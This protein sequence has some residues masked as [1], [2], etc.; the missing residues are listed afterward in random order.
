MTSISHN[1]PHCKSKEAS[2]LIVSEIKSQTDHYSWY[3]MARCGVC[4]EISLAQLMDTQSFSSGRYIGGSP[5]DTGRS[6]SIS[7]R[8]KIMVMYPEIE[9]SLVP[10]A[11]PDN[12]SASFVEAEKAIA[13]GLYSSAGACYRK[14][15]E[16]ALKVLHPEGK[17]TLSARIRQ[18]SNSQ[19]LPETLIG[20]LDHVRIFGNLSVH[21]EDE[22]P[23]KDDCDI[24]RD[25]T[26]LFLTYSFSLPAKI[27]KLAN[28]IGQD[29]T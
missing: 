15:V 20:L 7:E 9:T 27:A 10:E 14:S 2:F 13:N 11:L 22:D 5:M 23:T 24:A 18:L 3:T 4:K 1:C 26:R 6:N 25:F 19:R 21:D 8:Y 16:R 29:R 28:E 17:G 12:V